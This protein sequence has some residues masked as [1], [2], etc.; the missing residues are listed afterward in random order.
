MNDRDIIIMV[1]CI[2]RSIM[3]YNPRTIINMQIAYDIISVARK[4]LIIILV[5]LFLLWR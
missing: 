5:L 3:D 2:E 1:E 4:I